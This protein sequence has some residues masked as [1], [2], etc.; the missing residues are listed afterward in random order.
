MRSALSSDDAID[1]T[2]KKR[3][4]TNCG[5]YVTDVS[6]K[7]PKA[8]HNANL[9]TAFGCANIDLLCASGGKDFGVS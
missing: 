3:K 9:M 7:F 4:Q 2:D 1:S 6:E 5:T 8:K